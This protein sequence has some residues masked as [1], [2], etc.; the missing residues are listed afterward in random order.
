MLP[1]PDFV[2]WLEHD[3]VFVK[4]LDLAP[5]MEV[6]DAHP[7]LAQ[8]QLMRGAVNEREKRMGGTERGAAL[9][10]ALAGTATLVAT[11]VYGGKLVFDH[12]AGVPTA[13]LE[14]EMHERAEGHHHHGAE[15]A[16]GDADHEAAE[17]MHPGM[18]PAD[19]TA[20]APSSAAD[21]AGAALAPGGHTHAPGTPPHKD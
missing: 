11:A 4:P 5:L 8:M 14:A 3:F 13:V 12:A 9:A 20:G 18:S 15:A 6:L 1:G 10:L 17:P 16:G 19:S 21:S 2:F 7:T